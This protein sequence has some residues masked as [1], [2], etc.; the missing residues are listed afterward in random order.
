MLNSFN[1]YFI[2]SRNTR[3]FIYANQLKKIVQSDQITSNRHHFW[4]TTK[5]M[6]K[7]WKCFSCHQ[8]WVRGYWIFCYNKKGKAIHIVDSTINGEMWTNTLSGKCSVQNWD[9][10][11]ENMSISGEFKMRVNWENV[12]SSQRVHLLRSVFSHN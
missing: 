8:I 3:A 1:V 9:D 11:M 10:L 2:C 6:K 7:K 4:C 12:F 5:P